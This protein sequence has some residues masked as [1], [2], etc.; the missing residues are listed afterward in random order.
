MSARDATVLITPRSFGRHDE[1]L[2]SDAHAAF[3]QAVLRPGLDPAAPHRAELLA[4]ADG[5]IAGVEPIDAA[6]LDLAPR[7][8][9]IARYGVGV[10]NVD[11]EAA[12]TRGITVTNTPGANSVAVAELTIGL[13]L[14][15]AR[16]IVPAATAVRA[17][18]WEQVRGIGVAGRTLGLIGLGAIGREVARRA[19]G[20]DMRVIAYD[21]ALDDDA[22]RAAG[23]TPA[24]LDDVVAGADVL[25]LHVPVT[26]TTRRMVDADLIARMR[27]GAL[28]VNTARGELVDEAA[29]AD[30]LRDGRL[31]GAALD[32]LA[33]EPPPADHP[34]IGLTNVLV[35][36]HIGALTDAA[37]TAMGRGA[38][39][40]CVAVLDGRPPRHPV[41]PG[42]TGVTA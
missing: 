3:G 31:A 34:L 41:V 6:T 14:A 39:D 22:V 17:G 37:T 27:P 10:E 20:L 13:I 38:L 1:A 36:P 19:A 40:D 33:V 29:L 16:S 32:T 25:S 12:R 7:L 21:P 30:A 26:P 9:V 18:G 42:R 24:T 5:W 8:R 23:A 35:T 15:L 2:I 4:R 11:L 28:L